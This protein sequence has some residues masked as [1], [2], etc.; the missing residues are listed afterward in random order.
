MSALLCLIQSRVLLV[1]NC[2][3]GE[4]S[5]IIFFLQF[6]NW[7][8][9]FV[10]ISSISQWKAVVK[11]TSSNFTELF[12]TENISWE[13]SIGKCS[14]YLAGI[15]EP[16]LKSLMCLVQISHKKHDSCFT[17]ILGTLG[18]K[19]NLEIHEFSENSGFEE[20][21]FSGEETFHLNVTRNFL[22]I[23]FLEKVTL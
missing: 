23:Y 3:S 22:D 8:F 15:K 1:V 18:N 19:Q 10:C 4:H 16:T 13:Q 5:V 21:I 6:C 2:D 14:T 7:R 20:L 17:S 9:L 12:I 11:T